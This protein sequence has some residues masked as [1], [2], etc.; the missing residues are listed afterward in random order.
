MHVHGHDTLLRSTPSTSPVLWTDVQACGQRGGGL[1]ALALASRAAMADRRAPGPLSVDALRAALD[2]DAD[3][4]VHLVEVTTPVVQ[5]RVA[6]A[7][8]RRRGWR[9]RDVGQE[10]ADLTQDVFAALFV[11]D[12]RALRSWDPDKGMSLLNFVGMLAE[13]RVASILRSG[14]DRMSGWLSADGADPPGVVGPTA[15]AAVP[16]RLLLQQLLEALEA[17]LSPRAMELFVRLY[18]E[19]QSVEEVCAQTGLKPA[20]VHQWRHRLREAAQAVLRGLEGTEGPSI[21]A[22][23]HERARPVVAEGKGE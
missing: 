15:D 7:L 8:L 18:V 1:R 23:D 16:A 14:K 4:I 13:R 5:A 12:A 10:V 22:A 19:E 2:G 11:E 17:T 6:R 3:A 20:A 9:G 21:A